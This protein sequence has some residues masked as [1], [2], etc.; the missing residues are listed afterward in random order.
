VSVPIRILLQQ[1][2]PR[3]ERRAKRVKPE[4][5]RPVGNYIPP[6]MLGPG[7]V[8]RDWMERELAKKKDWIQLPCQQVKKK[9][10]AQGK[11]NLLYADYRFFTG[12]KLPAS[13]FSRCRAC[14]TML[15]G[16]VQRADHI[17]TCK[18][19]LW[20]SESYKVLN[21]QPTALLRLEQIS[22]REC[23]ICGTETSEGV[24]GV[25][26]CDKAECIDSW[27]FDDD[28]PSANLTAALTKVYDILRTTLEKSIS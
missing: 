10:T 28:M 18:C 1:H 2:H 17:A 14:R 5:P 22:K 11:G 27:M 21:L 19:T 15:L 4:I 9:V 7:M 26:L 12:T 20:L 3:G 23:L 25:P 6:R 16:H 24:W 8:N 13:Q